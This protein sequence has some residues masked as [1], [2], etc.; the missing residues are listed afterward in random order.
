MI[1]DF[2]EL[3]RGDWQ[4]KLIALFL[5]ACVAF[6]LWLAGWGCFVAV[7]SWYIP[8]KRDPRSLQNPRHILRA[9]RK[10]NVRGEPRSPKT[11]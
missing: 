5:A 8:D 11:L 10:S 1:S 2:I 7:D 4:E 6:C 9:L 3:L